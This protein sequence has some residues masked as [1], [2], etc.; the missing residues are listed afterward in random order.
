MRRGGS[1]ARQF[2]G[3][4]TTSFLGAPAGSA[5]QGAPAWMRWGDQQRGSGRH[6][7]RCCV[8]R[9]GE[10]AKRW[11]VW[12]RW[13]RGVNARGA[14]ISAPS[15][16]DDGGSRRERRLTPCLQVARHKG[17]TAC[18]VTSQRRFCVVRAGVSDD[19]DGSGP[20]IRNIRGGSEI[21]GPRTAR[22]SR[23]TPSSA[24]SRPGTGEVTRSGPSTA[25]G[26]P[27]PLRLR[28]PRRRHRLPGPED[29][30]SRRGVTGCARDCGWAVRSLDGRQRA[31]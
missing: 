22:G 6:G 28:R 15:R 17:S 29:R 9:C 21:P 30:L 19:V 27:P 16:A 5:E 8:S 25:P 24:P 26:V 14:K 23:R 13:A 10:Q 7:V 3:A 11:Q 2:T 18:R 4:I 31:S 12:T 20:G 1:G